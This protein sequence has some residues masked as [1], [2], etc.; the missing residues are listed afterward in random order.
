MAMVATPTMDLAM[1][2][3]AMDMA[4]IPIMDMAVSIHIAVLLRPNHPRDPNLPSPG[5]ND[6][7]AAQQHAPMYTL[8]QPHAP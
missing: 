8:T 3:A 1:D 2:M 6:G 7:P 5:S 4:D